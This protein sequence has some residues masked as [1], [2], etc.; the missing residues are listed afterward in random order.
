MWDYSLLCFSNKPT[1][2]VVLWQPR[3]IVQDLVRQVR[4]LPEQSSREPMQ[5]NST[6]DLELSE[7]EEESNNNHEPM[8]N[9]NLRHFQ[10][11]LEMDDD[12]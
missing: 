9:L 1:M 8:S 3:N 5:E 11:D 6:N 7:S 12:L 2:A 10:S 4:T